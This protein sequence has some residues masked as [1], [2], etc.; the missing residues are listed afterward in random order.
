[1]LRASFNPGDGK[2]DPCPIRSPDVH[3]LNSPG[4]AY[5]TDFLCEHRRL[6]NPCAELRIAESEGGESK[7]QQEE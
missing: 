7:N 1:M 6:D 3:V 2:N 5:R 4:N